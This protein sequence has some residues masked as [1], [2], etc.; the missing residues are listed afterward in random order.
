MTEIF[1]PVDWENRQRIA[2]SLRETL[3][4]EAGAGTGKTKSLVDRITS[5]VKDG[6]EIGRIAAITFTEAAAGELRDRVRRRLE[7]IAV[8]ENSEVCR[9]AV[10]EIDKASIQTLH[11]FAGSLLR[12]CPLE[13]GL[14]P[15]FEV[16]EEIEAWIDFEERWQK[17]LD[18]TM[19]SESEGEILIKALRLGLNLEK[20]K[21][22]AV[23]FHKNYD[24]LPDGFSQQEEPGR[25][26][27]SE[28]VK[29]M[30]MLA[31]WLSFARNSAGD[32]LV[33]HCLNLLEIAGRMEKVGPESDAGL[34][35]LGRAGKISCRR[36]SKKEWGNHPVDGVNACDFVKER[37]KELEVIVADGLEEVRRAVIVPLLEKLRQMIVDY[38]GQRKRNG[39]AQFQDLLIWARDMLKCSREARLYF[40]KKF[41]HILIDEFQDT[42]PIQA[43]IAFYMAE[44][45]GPSGEFETDWSKI[46]LDQGKLFVVGDPKQSIYRFRRAD[47]LTVSK[48]KDL[49]TAGGT[50]GCEVPLVQNFRSQYTVID[51]VNAV[52]E[53]CMQDDG[54]GNQACYIPLEARWKGETN[55]LATGVHYLGGPLEAKVDTVRR[56]EAGDISQT[57]F[58]MR[59]VP[60]LIRDEKGSGLRPAAYRDICILMPTRNGLPA[61]ERALDEKGI[62]YRVES[63]SL[64]LGT[65]DVK[66]LLS[67]MRAID[68][69]SDK[70]AL[71]AALRSSAFAMSDVE[72]TQFVENG[73]NLDYTN[74]GEADGPVRESLELLARYNRDHTWLTPA[75]TIESFIRERSMEEV[76]FGRSRP[77][78]RLRRLQFVVE[79]ARAFSEI[80]E[81]SLRGFLDWMEQLADEKARMVEIPVPETDED[82]VRIMTIHGA[83]G[84]EF[85][86]V[87][88]TG[89]GAGSRSKKPA[90][91]FDRRAN[92]VEVS[93]GTSDGPGFYTAGYDEICSN[94]EAAEE[95]ERMR[96]MYVAATRAKDHLVISLYRKVQKT[97]NSFAEKIERFCNDKPGIWKPVQLMQDAKITEES[98][99]AESF[100]DSEADLARWRSE[101]EKILEKASRPVSISATSIAR[102]NKESVE[103]VYPYRTGRG[104]TRLGRAV[105]SVLQSIDL[106]DG[107]GLEET[108]RAQSSNEGIP[109]KTNEVVRLVNNALNTSVVKRAVAS[110]RFYREVYVSAQTESGLVDG[111]VDLLFEEEDGLVVVDYKT[112]TIDEEPAESK[113]YLYSLQAGIYALITQQ[114]T[115]KRVKEVV[116]L[117][118][119]GPKEVQFTNLVEQMEIAKKAVKSAFQGS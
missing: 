52:F 28:F 1:Q 72:L 71:T 41:S 14:P 38:A 63:Q 94:E 37:L 106:R 3:F 46:K 118:L 75:E 10:E 93:L 84:R 91:L 116:L 53:E 40:Q 5:L 66:E 23:E 103:D 20:L 39:Q 78:E 26:F 50:Q 65:A 100:A 110:G 88:L 105:H 114:V 73:G 42:D 13:A 18:V 80:R 87:I 45:I 67:C 12:E 85:P 2:H 99:E 96:V 77:R 76:C 21:S 7:E 107:S 81:S 61:I 112:D 35:M 16:V 119:K 70:V 29:R 98:K 101:R 89:L 22:A 19:N 33:K 58:T 25:E 8:E 82:A 74:P 27:S 17:W 92:R 109:E 6:N 31:E 9:K 102:I 104:G 59:S 113:V 57:I 108:A 11:S 30:T 115:E 86:I 4:V 44:R 55:E 49:I 79:K 48:V 62:P 64:L 111:F 69:P 95:A 47:I 43:E 117:F 97:D 24:L 90:V 60:W 36:G 54:S 83:K 51:W 15:G 34:V 68:S 32:P 56:Q